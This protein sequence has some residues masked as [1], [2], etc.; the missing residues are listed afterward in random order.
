MTNSDIPE[1]FEQDLDEMF[2]DIWFDDRC[3]SDAYQE[4]VGEF[5][6]GYNVIH[7]LDAIIIVRKYDAALRQNHYAAK[8][9]RLRAMRNTFVTAFGPEMVD[10]LGLL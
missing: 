9:A 1:M 6:Q 4:G 3:C 5:D 8:G 7:S 2:C 10:R